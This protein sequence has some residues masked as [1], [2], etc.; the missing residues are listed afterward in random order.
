MQ[1]A[2]AALMGSVRDRILRLLYDAYFGVE[3]H[4][5]PSNRQIDR[6][7]PSPSHVIRPFDRT[8]PGWRTRARPVTNTEP[9]RRG[10]LVMVVDEATEEDHSEEQPYR[11]RIEHP[12]D[13]VPEPE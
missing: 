5:A 10:A 1:P 2:S 6:Q 11:A 9:I 7:L 12:D 4:T 3:E 13:S 8:R